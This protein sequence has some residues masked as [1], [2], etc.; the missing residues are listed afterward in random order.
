M[1][2]GVP[3]ETCIHIYTSLVFINIPHSLFDYLYVSVCSG[4]D[5]LSLLSRFLSNI[6]NLTELFLSPGASSNKFL[7]DVLGLKL[8]D[9]LF[10][11]CFLFSDFVNFAEMLMNFLKLH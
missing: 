11:D 10:F 2:G 1:T 8:N 7:L 4:S 3:L 6:N 5:D 9:G